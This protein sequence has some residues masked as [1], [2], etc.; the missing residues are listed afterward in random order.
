MDPLLHYRY[1]RRQEQEEEAEDLATNRINT[2]I[3]VP[4]IDG[5]LSDDEESCNPPKRKKICAPKHKVYFST[6]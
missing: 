1:K 3:N 2:A 4:I 6:Q 5:T